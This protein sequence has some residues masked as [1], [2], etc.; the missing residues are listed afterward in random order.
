MSTPLNTIVCN[1]PSFPKHYSNEKLFRASLSKYLTVNY[2]KKEKEQINKASAFHFL[3]V[4]VTVDEMGGP[5]TV[6]D[7]S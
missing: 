4:A 7:N 6:K 1:L 2:K 3:A 5:F